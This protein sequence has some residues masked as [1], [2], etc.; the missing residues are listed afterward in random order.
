MPQLP[1]VTPEYFEILVL[2]E[3][4]KMGLALGEPRILRRSELPEPEQ[5]FVLELAIPIDGKPSLV[6]CRAQQRSLG[7]DVIESA[8]ADLAF[9]FSTAEF[10]AEAVAGA[11]TRGVVLLRVVDGRTLFDAQEHCPSWLPAYMAQRVT[12]NRSTHG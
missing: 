5:G 2:R 1:K 11:E 4:R 7:N 12:S 6:I 8:S 10:T 9:V 3:L